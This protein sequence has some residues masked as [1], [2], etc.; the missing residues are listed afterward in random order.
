MMEIPKIIVIGDNTQAGTYILRILLQKDTELIFGH[1]K[2]GKPIHLPEGI[3]T[4]VG[5]AL[6]EKGA[7]SLARRLVRHATR[8]DDKPP[9]NIRKEMLSR[10]QEIELGPPYPL[11]KNGKKLF[12]NIDHFLDLDLAEII[13]V[14]AI[15]STERLESYI[16]EYLENDTK[17]QIIEKSLGANDSPKN[18]HVLHVN[19]D[20]QWWL[21]LPN[22][23]MVRFL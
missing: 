13:N 11:P 18:T 4:Y 17:T 23:L 15:R 6:S 21:N 12:W 1:F 3:Y 2:K 16:A 19:A 8:T 22:N 10:F 9:H 14:I 7:T 20:E 5:S